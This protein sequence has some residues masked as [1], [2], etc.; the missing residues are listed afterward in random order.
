MSPVS[1]QDFRNIAETRR[2][3]TIS[4]NQSSGNLQVRDNHALNRLI[5]WVRNKI[6][7][8]DPVRQQTE[9]ESAYNRF[10]GAV[11]KEIRYRDQLGW[12][13]DQLGADAYIKKPLT[14]RRVGEIMHQL[15]TRTTE[16]HRNTLVTAHYMAGREDSNYFDRTLAE[17]LDGRQVLQDVDFEFSQKEREALSQ[18]VYDAV[19]EAGAEGRNDIGHTEG[20][21]VAER[22]IDAELDRHEALIISAKNTA[23]QAGEQT[24][25]KAREIAAERPRPKA[26]MDSAAAA[27]TGQNAMPDARTSGAARGVRNLLS[28]ITRR[29]TGASGAS[30]ATAATGTTRSTGAKAAT[31]TTAAPQTKD[32]L[33]EL[34]QADLPRAVRTDMKKSIKAGG[35]KSFDA[36]VQQTNEKTYAWVRDNRFGKW[37]YDALKNSGVRVGNEATVPI[38]LDEKVEQLIS[39]SPYPVR[40]ADVKVNVRR[41]IDAYI[42]ENGAGAASGT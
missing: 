28:R 13:E 36:F 15:D 7:P 8:R 12:V 3:A 35:I 42:A 10:L 21:A 19:M 5:T 1:F 24:A 2:D 16:A 27:R 37:Y 11:G 17:K 31:G 33:N 9:R 32:L 29:S 14:S 22:A 6:S 26:E 23:R 25:Q 18:K 34:K 39:R 40:Y 4:V 41:E 20:S 30:G 38:P